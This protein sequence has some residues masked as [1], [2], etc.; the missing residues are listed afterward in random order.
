MR[1]IIF[2]LLFS[3]FLYA[4][5]YNDV[6]RVAIPALTTTALTDIGLDWKYAASISIAGS[7]M[8]GT[9]EGMKYN[10]PNALKRGMI[11]GAVGILFSYPIYIT[12]NRIGIIIEL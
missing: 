8:W 2:V 6:A 1:K 3:S 12:R 11:T 10:N 5:N 9:I 7:M 4:Q